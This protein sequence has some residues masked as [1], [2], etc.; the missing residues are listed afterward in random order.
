MLR[1]PACLKFGG[2]FGGQDTKRPASQ[3]CQAGRFELT[4]GVEHGGFEPPTPCLPGMSSRVQPHRFEIGV[5]RQGASD[6]AS[7]C[8]NCGPNCGPRIPRAAPRRAARP[9]DARSRPRADSDHGVERPPRTRLHRA[10][11][12]SRRVALRLRPAVGARRRGSPSPE[13]LR[14]PDQARRLSFGQSDLLTRIVS[15]QPA[16]SASYSGADCAA[17]NPRSSDVVGEGAAR[18]VL[19]RRGWRH[20]L[21]PPPLQTDRLWRSATPRAKPCWRRSAAT[22]PCGTC[23]PGTPTWPGRSRPTCPRLTSPAL[24]LSSS[25]SSPI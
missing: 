22:P 3:S 19:R 21:R 5:S 20:W 16:S 23:A 9:D 1:N 25:R 10:H 6:A 11:G 14:G 24:A 17:S 12:Q 8:S 15:R 13:A 7:C 18:A 4:I 2:Q